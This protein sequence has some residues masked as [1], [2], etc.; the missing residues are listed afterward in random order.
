[1]FRKIIVLLCCLYSVSL[2]AQAEIQELMERH[3]KAIASF[4]GFPP[5][6]FQAPDTE[7]KQHQLED[8]KGQILILHF[9]QLYCQPCLTQIPSLH[10]ILDTYD[11]QSVAVLSFVDDYGKDLQ[12]YLDENPMQY[13]VVPN[14]REFGLE[15]YGGM[16]GY[17]RVF[18]IDQY[19]VIRKLI[20]GGSSDDDLDLYEQINPLIAEF[21]K[22]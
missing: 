4:E 2:F 9:W 1:M 6:P 16:L 17:P 19:G 13:P 3:E 14:A 22:E 8:Y 12:D 10:K 21:L 11:D 18:I 20:R 5:I 7:G 15:A